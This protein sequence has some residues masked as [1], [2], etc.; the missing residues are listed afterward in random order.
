MKI[1]DYYYEFRQIADTTLNVKYDIPIGNLSWIKPFKRSGQP[2]SFYNY[3]K[4][5]LD[6]SSLPPSCSDVTDL[7]NKGVLY[8]I[9]C[10][11]KFYVGSTEDFGER[12]STHVKDSKKNDLGQEMYSDMV[13]E[14]ECFVFIFAI[15]DNNILL[16]AESDLIGECKN[17][18]IR[19]ACKFNEKSIK[20]I[21]ESI[22]DSK[23]YA[24]KYCYNIKN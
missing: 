24:S 2:I 1:P 13:K 6:E 21:S 14:G 7:S 4:M 16:S 9:F 11:G 10:N 20:F 8:G 18:S 19:K 17:Y 12:M 23:E 3:C 15:V 5:W 22:A